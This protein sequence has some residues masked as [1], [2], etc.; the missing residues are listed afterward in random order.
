VNTSGRRALLTL[1]TGVVA[2]VIALGALY[3]SG[4]FCALNARCIN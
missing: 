3:V 1:L 4:A 2:L